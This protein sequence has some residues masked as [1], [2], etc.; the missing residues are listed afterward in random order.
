MTFE[1][2]TDPEVIRIIMLEPHIYSA[3]RDDFMP[4]WR[5]AREQWQPIMHEQILYMLVRDGAETL[6]LWIFAP[7]SKCMMKVHTC[8]LPAAYGD[9]ASQAAKEMAQWFWENTENE[10][11]ITDVPVFNRHA[12]KFAEKAGMKRF[13]VNP[14]SFKRDGRF[15]DVIMLGMSRPEGVQCPSQQSAQLSVA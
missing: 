3:S 2:T 15:W 12:L 4:L 1:R 13:G 7:E 6:G 14:K 11:L 5:D 10:R 9:R 8:L